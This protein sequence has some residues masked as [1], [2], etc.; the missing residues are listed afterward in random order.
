MKRILIL[1]TTAALSGCETTGGQAALTVRSDGAAG[2]SWADNA[3]RAELMRGPDGL[4]AVT[5][6][7]AF[8]GHSGKQPVPAAR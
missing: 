2:I 4:T 7:R 1:I 5:F 6:S 3:M 8:A